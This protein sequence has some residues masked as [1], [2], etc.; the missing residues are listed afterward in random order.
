M[1][2]SPQRESYGWTTRSVALVAV[3]L[4]SQDPLRLVPGSDEVAGWAYSVSWFES[5][6]G[7]VMEDSGHHFSAALDAGL[8]EDRFEVVLD[9][10]LGNPWLV[11]DVS[12]G[13]A[14]A[15]EIG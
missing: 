7:V 8:V 2:E 11:G 14:L 10:A 6:E 4:V 3:S 12:G 13:E 15:D 5:G 9:G 1:N